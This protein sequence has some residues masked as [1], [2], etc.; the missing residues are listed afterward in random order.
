MRPHQIDPH[1]FV[2]L[3]ATGN[4]TRRKLLPALAHARAE[5]YLSDQS[6][7]LGAA[8]S[9]DVETNED[10]RS[11]AKQALVQSGFTVTA[12]TT[13]WIDRCFYYYPLNQGTIREYE[14]LSQ[15]MTMLEKQH[16]LPGNRIFYLALPPT[17][18]SS[19][20]ERLSEAGLNHGPGWTRVV[21]EKPFGRDLATA[22]ELNHT[23]HRNFDETQVYRI[24]HYLGKLTVQNVLV[25]RFANA[26]FESLWNRDRI[27]HVQITVAEPIGVEHR[28]EYYEQA[29]ALRD[30]VQN[31][32]TQLLA[33]MTM[34]I[35]VAFEANAI[36]D[37]KLKVLRSIRPPQSNEV[38]FGQYRPGT[39]HGHAVAGYRQEPGV[40]ADSHTETF[41]AAKLSIDNWRWHGV[42]FYLRTGKRL[43]RQLT[44]IAVTFRQPPISLFKSAGNVEPRP[45]VLLMTLQPDEGFSLSFDVKSSDKPLTLETQSLHFSYQ[46][47]YPVLPDAYETLILDV[48]SGDQTRFVRA[49]VAEASWQLY[50]PLL[51][52]RISPLSYDA[53]TWGPREAALLLARDGHAWRSVHEG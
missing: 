26:M 17:I 11:W 27:E 6:L 33:L 4:L 50:T 53:G 8:R 14:V 15:R 45:N 40:A 39:I 5:G 52:A 9:A 20:I 18:F 35:P 24:D 10:F 51:K 12:A 36:R 13:A 3:G 47:A 16:T 23:I 42:P 25:F 22:K 37:E 1:V 41:V 49:D 19:T 7:V 44:Q 32:L 21:V 30:M 43:P 46:D 38:V 34:E 2:I 28:A 48:M 29:G 31:H